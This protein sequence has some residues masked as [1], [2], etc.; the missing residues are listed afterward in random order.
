MDD[1]RVRRATA[2]E[3]EVLEE[4][5]RSTYVENGMAFP[6]L[7]HSKQDAWI[8]TGMGSQ[9]LAEVDSLVQLD[10]P[11][12]I[13]LSF[14]ATASPMIEA[15]A[16]SRS[17]REVSGGFLPHSSSRYVVYR[18]HLLA[19]PTNAKESHDIMGDFL[20]QAMEDD[21]VATP[22]S[23]DDPHH[24]DTSLL[25]SKNDLFASLLSNIPLGKLQAMAT[26]L[27]VDAAAVSIK[28][29]DNTTM[30]GNA[31]FD[32]DDSSSTTATRLSVPGINQHDPSLD[33]LVRL[34]MHQ[35]Q[36]PAQR[37]PLFNGNSTTIFSNHGVAHST[38]TP[39]VDV[40]AIAFDT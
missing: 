11:S 6:F 7:E 5:L 20:A 24:M 9:L 4:F 2:D 28:A 16:Q 12:C 30:S 35:L 8:C 40:P 39:P 14:V 33:S 31:A 27:D 32:I 3:H 18:K 26:S 19:S 10:I 29:Q 22:T 13:Y 21:D 17:F 1:T 15:W 38:H 25:Q 37:G 36:D 34:L 23:D